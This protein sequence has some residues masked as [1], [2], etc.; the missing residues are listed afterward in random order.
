MNV[1]YV[2]PR[3]YFHIAGRRVFKYLLHQIKWCCQEYFLR[4]Q[5][6]N[7]TF[8]L[9]CADVITLRQCSGRVECNVLCE[10]RHINARISASTRVSERMCLFFHFIILIILSMKSVPSV[11]TSRRNFRWNNWDLR[12]INMINMAF[13][14]EES[15]EIPDPCREKDEDPEE[16]IGWF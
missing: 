12:D 15:E 4:K 3:L 11:R 10:Y 8:I 9:M 5:R 14:K 6:M 1:Y 16:K 13:I 2:E 7:K